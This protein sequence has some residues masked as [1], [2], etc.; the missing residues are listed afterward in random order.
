MCLGTVSG[1]LCDITGVLA[2]SCS[3][4]DGA[5]IEGSIEAVQRLNEAGVKVKFL[6]NESQRT[7]QS[8]HQKLLRLG[9]CMK[10]E[11]IITPALAMA[12]I[13]K[14][15]SLTPH[16]LV[17]PNVLPDFGEPDQTKQPDCVVLG[18]AVDGFNYE[19]LNEAFQVLD[20][21]SSFPLF[22]LGKG[23]C[24]KEDGVR[25]LDVGPFTAALEFATERSAE[26]VGKPGPQFFLS[27]LEALGLGAED[28]GLVV[29]VGD[30]VVSDVG[31]AQEA[32]MRGVLVRTGKFRKQDETH[33]SVTPTLVVDNLKALVDVILEAKA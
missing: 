25:V 19:N 9:F 17:H 18:D 24:Y 1:L 16:L 32:G 11:D 8:L 29:M 14:Q 12:G 26:V 10:E 20:K 27:G 15:R 30:D 2:E 22:S 33:S 31:G 21:S 23:K 28:R 5:P 6:T 4:G 13:L 3:E 7:R